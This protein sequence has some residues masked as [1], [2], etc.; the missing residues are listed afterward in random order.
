MSTGSPPTRADIAVYLE[1]PPSVVAF[2][3]RLTCHG[4]IHFRNPRGVSDESG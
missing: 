4:H 2:D 1:E 3:L